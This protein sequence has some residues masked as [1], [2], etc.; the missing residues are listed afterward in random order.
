MSVVTGLDNRQLLP[1]Y[2]PTLRNEDSLF[3]YMLGY[4]Y[5]DLAVLDYPWATPHLPLD[6]RARSAETTDFGI[7]PAFPVFFHEWVNL[8][9][10]YCLAEDLPGRLE[11]LA[12]IFLDLGSASSEALTEMYRDERAHFASD[13]LTSLQEA[14]DAAG[15][16]PGNW[17]AYLQKAADKLQADMAAGD[18]LQEIRGTPRGL[19]G[20]ALIELW[21]GYWRQFGAALKAWP[22]IREA[23]RGVVERGVD[24]G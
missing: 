22:E 4:L 15:N 12:E 9:K 8:Q 10:Q 5:P 7:G 11:Q 6:D 14:S 3:G 13:A 2:F 16:A 23:A 21:R 19:K 18:P 17:K 1:P 20:E 24:W